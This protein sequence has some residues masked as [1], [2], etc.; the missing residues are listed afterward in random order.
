MRYS[1]ADIPPLPTSSMSGSFQCPGPAYGASGAFCAMIDRTLGQVSLISPVV[2]HNW[3]TPVAQFHG[4][5]EPH[6]HMA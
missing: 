1:T 3:A 2:R 5:D 6:S 4:R